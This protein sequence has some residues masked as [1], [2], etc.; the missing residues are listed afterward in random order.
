MIKVE[1]TSLNF[2]RV[3]KNN[4]FHSFEVEIKPLNVV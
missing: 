3:A 4:L 2:T 1:K